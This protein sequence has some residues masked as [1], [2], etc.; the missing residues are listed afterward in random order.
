MSTAS[1]S[2]AAAAYATFALQQPLS[3]DQLAEATDAGSLP[4]ASAQTPDWFAAA[5]SAGSS[6]ETTAPE[7]VV[8]QAGSSDTAQE[9]LDLVRIYAPEL[10]PPSGVRPPAP[11]ART[12]TAATAPVVEPSVPRAEDDHL[13]M[14][15]ELGNLES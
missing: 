3:L 6:L 4:L 1:A 9:R 12:A 7:L 5:G 14:I 13:G 8:S 15:K 2:L 10:T 11:V